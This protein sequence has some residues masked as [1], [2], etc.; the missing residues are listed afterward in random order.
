[1]FVDVSSDP[2]HPISYPIPSHQMSSIDRAIDMQFEQGLQRRD[3]RMIHMLPCEE[4]R[5]RAILGQVS[6]GR[7]PARR[8]TGRPCRAKH[9]KLI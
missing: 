2:F 3:C 5:L 1:M 4:D 6:Q 7:R 8:G 9:M